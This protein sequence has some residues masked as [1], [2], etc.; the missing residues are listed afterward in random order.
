MEVASTLSVSLEAVAEPRSFPGASDPWEEHLRTVG[1]DDR[2]ET[3][4]S[5]LPVNVLLLIHGVLLLHL[6]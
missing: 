4:G 2:L 3:A 6:F 1:E 5:E